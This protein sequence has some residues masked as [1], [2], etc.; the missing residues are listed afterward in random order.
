MYR[1]LFKFAVMTI[2]I[3]SANLLTNKI[4]DF[5]IGYKMHYK[6][7]TYTLIAMAIITLILYPLYAYLEK[8]LTIL[9]TKIVK[10]G[11]SWWQIHWVNNNIPAMPGCSILFLR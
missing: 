6:P 9:S 4:G 10:S 1:K 2:T 11:R 3:L 8:W 5:L 7:L